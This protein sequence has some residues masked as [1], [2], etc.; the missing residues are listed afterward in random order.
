MTVHA[1][2]SSNDVAGKLRDGAYELP[3]GATVAALVELA[4]RESGYE[5][6]EEQKDNFVF[7]FDNSP[8]SYETGL[9]D[10]GK[11]RVLFKITGG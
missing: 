9:R 11:L 5:L 4:Q 10:G 8:A 7:V 2:F 3:E 1:R 6:S